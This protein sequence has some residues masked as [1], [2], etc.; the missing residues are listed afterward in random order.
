M[1]VKIHVGDCR[2]V[3]RG[4]MTGDA[5]MFVDVEIIETP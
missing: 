2:D 5:P 4:M 3:L 1:T